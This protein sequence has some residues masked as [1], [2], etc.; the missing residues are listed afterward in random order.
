M[1]EQIGYWGL[2]VLGFGFLIFIHELGHFA[3]AKLVGIRVIRFAFGFGPRLLGTNKN[4]D[5]EAEE[6]RPGK[7]DY[8]IRLIPCGGYVKMAG[9]EIAEGKEA[10]GAA[11]EFPSKTP[12]QRALVIIAGPAMSILCAIPLL[13]LV[14][15][16]GM[17]RPSSRVSQIVPERAAWNSTL[18]RGDLITG[19]KERGETN[20]QEVRLWREVQMN[21]L[22]QERVGDIV[23]R[24]DRDG[25]TIEI[26][27]TT[28]EQGRIGVSYG[29]VGQGA[30]YVT[31]LAGYREPGS[32]A[33][34]AGIEPG[35]RLLR[36]GETSVHAWQDFQRTVQLHPNT[37]LPVELVTPDGERRTLDVATNKTP[38]WSLGIIALWPSRLG[39]VRPNFPADRAGLE[40][41][42]TIAAVN[43][44]EVQD[45]HVL[46]QLILNAAPGE[47]VLTVRRNR[48]DGEAGPPETVNVTLEPGMDIHDVL[49][50]ARSKHPVVRGFIDGA[51]AAEAGIKV[52]AILLKCEP[53]NGSAQ[54]EIMNWPDPVHL[55]EL[56]EYREG[57]APDRYTVTVEQEGEEM[58]AAVSAVRAY[59]G[60]IGLAPRLD[61][62]RTVDPGRPVAAL[63]QGIVETGQ[64]MSLAVRSLYMLVTGRLSMEMLSGPV[65][66]VTA[67]RY[68]AEAGF[69]T[70]I[71]FLV[72]VTVHLGIINL[73]PLPVLDGGHL[74]FL[75]IE[76]IRGKPLPDRVMGAIMYAGLI[77]LLA[78]MA[79]VTLNDI[80]K[81]T[82][83]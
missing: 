48:D 73:V 35:S 75:G 38:Y 66:I 59:R 6:K 2:V 41:G 36:I 29:F 61:T 22:L 82:N 21:S 43:D 55:H 58:T 70:F 50:V 49:G 24:V 83:L 46:K 71:E 45:W 18:K 32:P 1:I 65:M 80:L 77:A 7:T 44:Q 20:F 15:M 39:P 37:T 16:I 4:A 56:A 52:G 27:L 30:G 79:F 31:T 10:T 9:G 69:T 78:L 54:P 23:L 76:K 42:D 47:V 19:I 72:M 62:T 25:E 26:E 53:A 51:P 12:G 57:A 34:Q 11:D 8:C 40:T 63:W 68:T 64:W 60:Q 33:H 28:D 81:L 3:A 5:I 67:T 13:A 74:A 14:F 17:E